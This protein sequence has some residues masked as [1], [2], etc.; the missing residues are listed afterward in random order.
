M[1]TMK[2]ITLANEKG[3][4]GKTTLAIHIAAGLAIRGAKV[5]LIDADGQGHATFGMGLNKA[6][7][8]YDMV[9]RGAAW[10]DIIR[11]LAPESYEPP[12]EA[13]KGFLAVLPGNSETMLIGQKVE[14][15]LTINARLEE[16]AGLFDVV[17]FD[18]SPT[19]SLLH[20]IIYMATDGIIYPTECETYSLQALTATYN[21]LNVFSRQRQK[22]TGV[23]VDTLGIVPMMHKNTIE[24]NEN[25]AD[26][27]TNFGDMV[28]A[29]IPNRVTW[30]EASKRCTP[31]FRYAPRSAAAREA[32][33]LVNG[34]LAYVG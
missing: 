22:L 27:R 20:G 10:A 8:F 29:P 2:V 14:N 16:L 5:L 1:Q 3:G 7:G 4:V 6:P 34:V 30:V 9:V 19:P 23:G 13:S 12:T 24:H 28:T 21:N 26:L 11:P 25:L 33:A 17:L 32:W 15:S 18:T 31:V